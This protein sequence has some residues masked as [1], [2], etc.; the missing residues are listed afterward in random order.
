MTGQELIDKIIELGAENKNVKIFIED[1]GDVVS[2]E[3][4]NLNLYNWDNNCI[5]L[6]YQIEEMM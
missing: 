3:K 6:T 4:E 1:T 5:F 2:V